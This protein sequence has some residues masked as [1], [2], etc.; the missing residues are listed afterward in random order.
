MPINH[1]HTLRSASLWRNRDYLLLMTGQGVSTLG[2]SMSQIAYPLLALALTGSPAQAGIVG[3]LNVLPF[4]LF[5]LPAGVLMDRWNRK[6]VM[7]FCEIARA[8][9]FLSI[10]LALALG[11]LTMTQLFITAAVQGSFAVF[12]EIAEV[13]SIP[14]LVP[15]EH[16]PTALAAHNSVITTLSV[17]GPQLGGILFQLGRGLPF[18]ADALS[19]L[20]SGGSL[21]LMRTPFQA[22]R[23]LRQ[24][25]LRH[26]LF[27]GVRWLW[28]HPL[29]RFL[30]FYGGI[31]FFVVFY[32]GELIVI[33]FA[34][35]QFHA[36]AI[37]IGLVFSIAELGRIP[38][39]L[40]VPYVGKHLRVGTVV[41]LAGW[42]TAFLTLLLLAAPTVWVLGMVVA[43]EYLIAAIY[44]AVVFGY[45][46]GLI[47]DA[48]QGRVN[49]VM[50][51]IIFG[52][53]SLGVAGTGALL[54]WIGITPTIAVFAA[55]MVLFVI[56]AMLNRHVRH[57][58]SVS[59]D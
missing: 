21:L 18:F 56:M 1:D 22:E 53:Q 44:D 25:T 13:A 7:L 2:T 58:S 42:L 11:H 17:S 39:T 3:A 34:Q 26:E 8:L 33:L 47:P 20:V 55:L 43:A 24:H 40:L 27:E 46:L 31:Y 29:V 54:Q 48:L 19:Y 38:G 9:C 50:R 10:P 49:S 35:R 45:E 14:R 41:I 15:K 51:L 4:L 6:R 23:P 12:F 16:L 28:Q 5:S 57:T 32:G 36:S 37:L 52:I 59:P 30:T